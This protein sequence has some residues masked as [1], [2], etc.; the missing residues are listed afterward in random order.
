MSQLTTNSSYSE[1][2]LRAQENIWAYEED[3]ALKLRIPL[4]RQWRPIGVLS[5]R[6]EHH[7]HIKSKAIP[8]TDRE[9]RIGMF[10]VRYKEHLHIKK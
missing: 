2:C 3:I 5:V 9:G 1:Q 6:Y 4:N 8:V 7:P 10:P